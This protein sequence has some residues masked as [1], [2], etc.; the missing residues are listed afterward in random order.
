MSAKRYSSTAILLAAVLAL[1]VGFELGG[2][3]TALRL[4]PNHPVSTGTGQLMVNP[5]Q[6]ADLGILWTAWHTLL[7]SY[8][9]PETINP[10]KLVLGAAA[11]LVRAVGDPYT[12]FMPPQEA[13]DFQDSLDGRL[14]GIGAELKEQS[15]SIIVIAPIK[16]SPAEHA[17]LLKDDIIV[18]ID[19]VS[20]DGLSLDQVV[21]KIRG[22]KGT[23]VVLTLLRKKELKPIHLSIVRDTIHVPS[24]E[25][26]IIKTQSGAIGY[27]ALSQF[28][29]DSV[30]EEQAA[31]EAFKAEKTP[32]KGIVLDLRGNGGGYLEGAVS[33]V[34]FFQKE[35]RVVSVERRGGVR[36]DH[37]V[38]GHII[39]PT[40]PLVILINEGSASASEITA[41]ALQDHKR[42]LT[43]GMT[44]FGKGT[45]QEVIPLQGGST[46]RVTVAHWITPGGKNL[47]K[48]GVHP[49][50]PAGITSA[51][52]QAKKDPQLDAAEKA[53]FTHKWVD[54]IVQ[55]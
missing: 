3:Q 9:S 21:S 26:R 51:D 4:N 8:I 46:M 49:D 35:G 42:A 12:V 44:S 1:L 28:G 30:K 11:G 43:V 36:D 24:V 38:N 16:N 45:V 22:A 5:E 10:Q 31:L 15:G 40:T 18:E 7:D 34:S 41:G 48:E 52:M 29:E 20:T 54:G 53:L 23:T 25:S 33:L 47:A 13:K 2:Y 50:V 55:K 14:E 17:G 37:D 6:E 39:F 32:L 19:S 27:L